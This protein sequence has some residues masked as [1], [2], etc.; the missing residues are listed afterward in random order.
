MNAIDV[1]G[2]EFTYPNGTEAV[3]DMNFTVSNG[4]FFG[5]LGPNGSGKTT[6]I[7]M[8][9]TLLRP[10]RGDIS[11]N[12]FDL[13][14][15]PVAIRNSIGYNAQDTG[16][17][18]DLTARENIQVACE[19]YH[20]PK[21]ERAE[22]IDDLLRLADLEAAADNRARTFSGGMQRRLDIAT[23]LVH[24]PL[25]VFL[26]EPTTG[27]DPEA[28]LR[29]WEYFREINAHG[30]TIFLTTQNLEEADQLCSRIAVIADGE[31][32]ASGSPA[33][34]KTQVGEDSLDITFENASP[35]D[36]E[37]ARSVVEDAGMLTDET[38]AVGITEDGIVVTSSHTRQIATDLLLAL[39][40]AGF[41]VTGFTVR[42]PTLDDVFLSVTGSTLR[43]G[44]ED[45]STIDEDSPG[46]V[47]VR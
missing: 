5:F 14:E 4:E 46:Q 37:R 6:T 21:D 43:D 19:A 7:K 27:L 18:D 3:N 36:R 32:V 30:T 23:S 28:R 16:V 42:S 12:G 24:Q 45:A 34:L 15:E 40:E 22:R 9:V 1:T 39:R 38:D 20:V 35:A 11:V 29:L 26:D 44:H 8:L 13:T 25:L 10:T 2:V 41:D 33:A 47:V 17:W 31:I